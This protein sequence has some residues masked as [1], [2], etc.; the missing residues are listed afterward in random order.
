MKRVWR[1]TLGI[2]ATFA[3]IV[4]AGLIVLRW[5]FYDPNAC[6]REDKVL[7][8]AADGSSISYRYE[9]CTTIGTTVLATVSLVSP[10]GWRR[11]IFRY[12]PAFGIISFRGIATQPPLE[13][14]AT[15]ISPH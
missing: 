1:I 13:P 8:T 14:S 11:T 9:A 7:S 15:W 5:F 3:L 4:V 6:V 2:A 10:W 12:D